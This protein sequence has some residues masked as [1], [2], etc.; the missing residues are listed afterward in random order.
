[1]DD[2]KEQFKQCH[3]MFKLSNWHMNKGT[4]VVSCEPVDQVSKFMFKHKNAGV[5]SHILSLLGEKRGYGDLRDATKERLLEV[6]LELR[7]LLKE[8]N[9]SYRW[10]WDI[11][12]DEEGAVVS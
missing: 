1:M 4:V 6:A 3:L 10:L 12:V 8:S 2:N 7:L 9:C 5:A 11:E